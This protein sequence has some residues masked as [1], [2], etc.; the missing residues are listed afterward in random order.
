MMRLVVLAALFIITT[1]CY[2]RSETDVRIERSEAKLHCSMV[3]ASV[4]KK[5][6][7]YPLWEF[8]GW[9][10]GIP[11]ISNQRAEI[12]FYDLTTHVLQR[13]AVIKPPAGFEV[14][15]N[16]TLGWWDQD[17]LYLVYSG[18]PKNTRDSNCK[19]KYAYKKLLDTGRIISVEQMLQPTQEVSDGYKEC[20]AYMQGGT[21]TIGPNGGPW[22]EILYLDENKKLAISA[23]TGE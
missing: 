12:Y 20:T 18:C 9:S 7:Q 15:F 21:I 16:V 22:R 1:G 3:A 8:S 6:Y 2:G 5:N 23:H 10:R 11:R 17:G 4:M 14:Q 13:K 19:L